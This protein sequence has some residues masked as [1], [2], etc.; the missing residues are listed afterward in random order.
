MKNFIQE[1][2]DHV[3]KLGADSCDVIV[4]TGDSLSLSAIN[5]K[6]DKYKVAKTQ[7][8]GLRV[9]KNNRIGL[10]Y[11]ESFDK[12]AIAFA[13]KCALENSVY[14]DINEYENI[15]IKNSIRLKT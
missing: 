14:S 1:T 13:S 5:G 12:D 15:S 9:I 4:S 10:S 6:L 2:I 8:F 3:M 7:V 11:S